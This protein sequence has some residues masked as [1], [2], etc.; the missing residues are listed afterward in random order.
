MTRKDNAAGCTCGTTLQVISFPAGTYPDMAVFLQTK[1][2]FEPL[3]KQ[4]TNRKI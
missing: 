2:R 4:I 3:F 1:L